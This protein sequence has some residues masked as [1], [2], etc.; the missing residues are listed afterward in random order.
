MRIYIQ[1]YIH[2]PSQIAFKLVELQGWVPNISEYKAAIV[3][4]RVSRTLNFI[5][6]SRTEW[7]I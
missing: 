4:V 6:M 2:I 3:E 5:E 1:T 7:V